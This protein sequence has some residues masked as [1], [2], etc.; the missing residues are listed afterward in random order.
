MEPHLE[1]FHDS[2]DVLEAAFED[3]PHGS[4]ISRAM[5]EA[6][7]CFRRSGAAI[8]AGISQRR[9]LTSNADYCEVDCQYVLASPESGLANQ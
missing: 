9:W 2:G 4:W 3:K 5:F 6:Y 1:V 8:E 7:Q